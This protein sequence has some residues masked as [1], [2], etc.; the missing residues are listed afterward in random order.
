MPDHQ[1]P[2]DAPLDVEVIKELLR[3]NFGTDYGLS[4][5]RWKSR[6]H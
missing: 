2:D 4:E 3:L 6:F 5:V 1:L